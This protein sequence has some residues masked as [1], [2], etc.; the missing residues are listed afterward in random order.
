MILK[1]YSWSYHADVARSNTAKPMNCRMLSSVLN[2]VD[3]VYNCTQPSTHDYKRNSNARYIGCRHEHVTPDNKISALPECVC[4][5][6]AHGQTILTQP[7]HRRTS[8]DSHSLAY[9]MKV[10]RGHPRVQPRQVSLQTFRKTVR[11]KPNHI[12]RADYVICTA[13]HAYTFT[14]VLS[15]RTYE[16]V[17][18]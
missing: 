2:N 11:V 8:V 3:A 17:C 15:F 7:Q 1:I 9:R 13:L 16:F 4:D 12:T 18:I 5:L 14:E 6:V 10:L